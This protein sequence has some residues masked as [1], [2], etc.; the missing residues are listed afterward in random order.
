[1]NVIVKNVNKYQQNARIADNIL[2]SIMRKSLMKILKD[3]NTYF[4]LLKKI[5]CFIKVIAQTQNRKIKM[6]KSQIDFGDGTSTIFTQAELKELESRSKGSRKDYTGIFASR[7]KPKIIELFHW[8]RQ[9]DK[10]AELIIP[11]S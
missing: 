7:V 6:N 8:F 11:K 1:M 10:L 2:N 3:Y 9:K 5:L 4:L